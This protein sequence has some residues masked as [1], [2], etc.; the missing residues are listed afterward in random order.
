MAL[1]WGFQG[2][3]GGS[4]FPGC[5]QGRAAWGPQGQVLVGD[6][7]VKGEFTVGCGA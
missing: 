4:T 1:Q 7:V 5:V 6:S 3:G 2:G